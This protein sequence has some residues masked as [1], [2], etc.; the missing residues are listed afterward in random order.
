[1]V[2]IRVWI[3]WRLMNVVMWLVRSPKTDAER[4]LAQLC[5]ERD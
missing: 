1:M 3:A 5:P 4:R 2:A